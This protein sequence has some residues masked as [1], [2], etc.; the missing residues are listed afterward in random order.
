MVRPYRLPIDEDQVEPEQEQIEF[1]EWLGDMDVELRRFL[2]SLDPDV[3]EALDFSPESLDVIE[4]WILS[5]YPHFSDM[6]AD[7]EEWNL[8]GLARY[9]GETIRKNVEGHWELE[10]DPDVIYYGLPQLTGFSS[11]PTP[12]AP[13]RLATYTADRRNG[14]YLR[15][16]LNNMIEDYGHQ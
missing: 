2:D 1:N 12:V 13:H 5:R 6:L 8:D 14:T 4:S 15:T 11:E 10:L 7:G 16:I 9:I 3:R